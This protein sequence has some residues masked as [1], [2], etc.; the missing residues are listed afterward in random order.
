MCAKAHQYEISLC[1]RW[2]LIF[3]QKKK[4]SKSRWN[5]Q[6][7]HQII[8]IFKKVYFYLQISPWWAANELTIGVPGGQVW[9]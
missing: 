1:L 7:K 5:K 8:F 2:S 3:S 9:G 6:G 4:K